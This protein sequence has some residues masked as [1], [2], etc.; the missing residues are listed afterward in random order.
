MSPRDERTSE[1]RLH[2]MKPGVSSNSRVGVS[3]SLSPSVSECSPEGTARSRKM[4]TGDSRTRA[5]KAAG[6]CSLVL[7]VEEGFQAGIACAADGK[8]CAVREDC[9][10]AVFAVGLDARD[11][12]E[13]DEVGAVDTYEESRVERQFEA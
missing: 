3:G 9:H 11:A 1:H 10:F 2:E 5:L 8:A 7:F 13:V 6:H 12:L 4:Q